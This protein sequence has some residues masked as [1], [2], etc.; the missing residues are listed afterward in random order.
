MKQQTSAQ[1]LNIYIGESDHYKGGPL[2][3]AIVTHLKERGIAGV[4]VFHGVEGFGSSG[5]LHTARFEVLFQGLPIVVQAVDTAEHISQALEVLDELL[6][7][8]LVTIHD[9]Q[10][11]RYSKEPKA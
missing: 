11:I 3:A 6:T 8:A 7:E 10:A 2:Y 5:K 9:V 1:V 4:T